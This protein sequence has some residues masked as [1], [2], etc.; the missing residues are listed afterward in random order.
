MAFRGLEFPVVGQVASSVDRARPGPRCGP[1]L[2]FSPSLVA[3]FWA[4]VEQVENEEVEEA[5]HHTFRN[6]PAHRCTNISKY[7]IL[8]SRYKPHLKLF[9]ETDLISQGVR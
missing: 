3:V 4:V 8:V 9:S 2:Q 1:R 5:L 7:D 6:D